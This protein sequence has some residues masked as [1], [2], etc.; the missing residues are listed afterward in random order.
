M[1][2]L[3]CSPPERKM[4]ITRFF[5]RSLE[6]MEKALRADIYLL[7]APGSCP[8]QVEQPEKDP[9]IALRYSCIYWVEH[10]CNSQLDSN[11]TYND[12]LQDG[13]LVETFLR[14]KYLY[15][16]EALS[17]CKTIQEGMGSITRLLNIVKRRHNATRLTSL[18]QDAR[19]F[20]NHH[21]LTI[22]EA[23]LQLYSS[24]LVFSP[25]ENLI[26]NLFKEEIPDWIMHEPSHWHRYPQP[27]GSHQ[28]RVNSVAISPDGS[29]A[30]SGSDDE[31]AILWSIETGE[32]LRVL[33]DHS[34][35]VYLVLFSPNGNVLASG[36]YDDT[37]RLWDV[38]T[39][40]C[41]RIVEV[42][43]PFS[44]E[45]VFDQ[46]QF[47]FTE[48]DDTSSLDCLRRRIGTYSRSSDD[49]GRSYCF[50]YDLNPACDWITLNGNNILCLP[51]FCGAWVSAVSGSAVV[52]GCVSGEIFIFRFDAKKLF[53]LPGFCS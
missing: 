3:S 49:N 46:D 6:A 17:H 45:V 38:E 2:L 5:S 50:D 26:R 48:I 23:P 21:L 7:G 43:N 16:L 14:K 29:I 28:N 33:S 37:V 20:I 41:L 13:G 47:H 35:R 39:G 19:Q 9:L 36:S 18:V 25:R 8:H 10:L 12:S 40:L 44:E 27:C 24:A 34:D 42:G 11:T 15:W 51:V 22:R 1:R 32:L 4:L 53:K 30:A 31:T 52:V